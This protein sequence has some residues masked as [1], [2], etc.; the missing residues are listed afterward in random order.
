MLNIQKIRKNYF[1]VSLSLSQVADLDIKKTKKINYGLVKKK[2]KIAIF[3]PR[4]L[5]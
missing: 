4:M 1:S 3:F 2:S 5:G